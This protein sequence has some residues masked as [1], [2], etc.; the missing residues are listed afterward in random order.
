MNKIIGIAADAAAAGPGPAVE[1]T[2]PIVVERE[3][4]SV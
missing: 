1:P 4:A 2:R 3:L